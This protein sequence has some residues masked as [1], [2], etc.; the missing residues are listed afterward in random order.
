[1]AREMPS[2]HKDLF[3]KM[4][5]A[6]FDAAVKRLDQRIP[7][8][9]RNQIIVEMMKIVAMVGDGHSNIYPTRDEKIGFHSLPIKLYLFKDGLFVRTADR[10]HA[11]LVGA[12]VVKIGDASPDDAV[13]RI[14]PLIGH[15]NEMG[16]RFFATSL[17]AIIM[18]HPF[19][20][21]V[22]FGIIFSVVALIA[23]SSYF[24]GISL[25]FK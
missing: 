17:L 20:E 11:D 14:A 7:S 12:R 1:M 18:W 15:D 5:R 8:L 10:A 6:D 23:N 24:I 13:N 21:E 3:H 25:I 16:V 4:S 22:E 19:A 2:T 9:K